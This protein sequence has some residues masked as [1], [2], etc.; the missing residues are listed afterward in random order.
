MG[1]EEVRLFILDI[2]GYTRFLVN[3]D[4]SHARETISEILNNLFEF[5]PKDLVLNK[6]EGDALF[7]YTNTMSKEVLWSLGKEIYKYFNEVILKQISEMH[8]NCQ[9]TLCRNIH[10][11][12]IK[13]FIH[14]GEIAFHAL[15]DFNELIGKSV[16]EI[17]RVMKNSINNDSYILTIDE[18][19]PYFDKY[20]YL[21]KIHY[22]VTHLEDE[23]VSFHLIKRMLNPYR[24]D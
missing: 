10:D 12:D 21:G 22:N 6:I 14:E 5:A 16:I 9:F 15:G 24:G 18:S 17:H 13:F 7:F 11:M 23:K 8:R 20:K 2:S 4:L 19:G 1:T 3:T